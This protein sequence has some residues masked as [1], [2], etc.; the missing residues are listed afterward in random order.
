M[1]DTPTPML[2]CPFCNCEAEIV[3]ANNEEGQTWLEASCINCGATAPDITAWNTR[4][5]RPDVGRP[6]FE[7]SSVAKKDYD[8]GNY[9]S[10]YVELLI[11]KDAQDRFIDK[12]L[13]EKP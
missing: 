12:L 5:P 11:H 8:E 6:K 3:E 1:T 10:A 7:W 9:Y 4:A 2:P 13:G